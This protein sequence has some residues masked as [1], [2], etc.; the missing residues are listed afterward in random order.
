VRDGRAAS[1]RQTVG[2]PELTPAS[3]HP[4]RVLTVPRRESLGLLLG[5]G[6]FVAVGILLFGLLTPIRE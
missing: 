6:A 2:V 3:E 4:R 1:L 5:C